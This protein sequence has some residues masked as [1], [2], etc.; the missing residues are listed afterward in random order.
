MLSWQPGFTFMMFPSAPFLTLTLETARAS[1]WPD[2]Y[3]TLFVFPLCVKVHNYR[4]FLLVYDVYKSVCYNDVHEN[5]M[6]SRQFLVVRVLPRNCSISRW[7]YYLR[8]FQFERTPTC[9]YLYVVISSH[10]WASALT[11][12]LV[13]GWISGCYTEKRIWKDAFKLRAGVRTWQQA[14]SLRVSRLSCHHAR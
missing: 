2:L 11:A 4:T 3:R 6:I 10:H 1:S 9:H 14:Y 12:I 7:W 5:I 13:W 8:I